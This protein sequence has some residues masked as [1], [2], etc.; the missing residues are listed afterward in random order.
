MTFTTLS[1]TFLK[2]LPP[3][4]RKTKSVQRSFL[5]WVGKVLTLVKVNFEFFFNE[6]VLYFV[7]LFS[8]TLVKTSNS[9]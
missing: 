6:L 1:L 3:P 9:F 4:T 8:E 5:K 7:I 2:T